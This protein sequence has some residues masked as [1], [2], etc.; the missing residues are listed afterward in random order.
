VPSAVP[1]AA[2]AFRTGLNWRCATSVATRHPVRL[3]VR[4][5]YPHSEETQ[6]GSRV[7]PPPQF[8]TQVT[9]LCPDTIT[10]RQE[11]DASAPR[12][13]IRPHRLLPA[14]AGSLPVA[15]RRS[16]HPAGPV[17][18]ANAVNSY[19]RRLTIISPQ[20]GTYRICAG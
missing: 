19:A 7:S 5:N 16:G 9:E 17:P 10:G 14:A 15:S 2:E 4:A 13:L 11:M 6:I 8:V 12:A 3:L 1:Q 18:A 20:A